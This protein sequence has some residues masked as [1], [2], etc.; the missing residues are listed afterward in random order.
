M[1]E[2]LYTAS[3]PNP[4]MT[5]TICD[6]TQTHKEHWIVVH[7]L[8]LWINNFA[9]AT[10]MSDSLFYLFIYFTFLYWPCREFDPTVDSKSTMLCSSCTQ[11]SK[12][13]TTFVLH[14]P[15]QIMGFRVQ[16][17]HCHVLS[18]SPFMTQTQVWKCVCMFECVKCA[19]GCVCVC[20]YLLYTSQ[21]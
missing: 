15:F 18:E 16:Q 1:P 8:Y 5:I 9:F 6:T 13:K 12:K 4:C 3:L 20:V 14:K 11:C 2:E 7:L 17:C 19:H 21:A 10:S